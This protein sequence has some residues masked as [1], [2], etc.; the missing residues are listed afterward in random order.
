MVWSE[1]NFLESQQ[2]DCYLHIYC[3]IHS[4]D[5]AWN[6]GENTFKSLL[7]YAV[8]LRI[9]SR[10]LWSRSLF[11]FKTD[12][13][14]LIHLCFCPWNS[15]FIC[16]FA[17]KLTTGVIMFHKVPLTDLPKRGL[18]ISD[19]TRIHH[20]LK[21]VPV[22]GLSNPLTGF[23]KNVLCKILFI[24][25]WFQGVQTLHCCIIR[26]EC[27]LGMT[28]ILLVLYSLWTSQIWIVQVL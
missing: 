2:A 3:D 21:W 6:V 18:I 24:P 27:T 20:V 1:W 7:R 28:S 10:K 26:G 16:S 25:L 9:H 19:G 5:S 4:L 12:L 17:I 13:V 8:P 14:L 11:Y 15:D 22:H 23:P